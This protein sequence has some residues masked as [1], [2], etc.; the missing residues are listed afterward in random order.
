MPD[1]LTQFETYASRWLR[2]WQSK[3]H[4]HVAGKSRQSSLSSASAWHGAI[5][6]S[7]PHCDAHF[8]TA[9]F[10]HTSPSVSS[11]Q[12]HR[13]SS[14]LHTPRTSQPAAHGLRGGPVGCGDGGGGGGEAAAVR[15]R[16]RRGR[17]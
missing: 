8:G 4:S 2:R 14:E 15:R 16:R 17:N 5:G 3:R 10:S 12:S 11:G 6:S 9:G 1:A 7:R 13:P